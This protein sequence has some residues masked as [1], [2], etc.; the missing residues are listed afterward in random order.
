MKQAIL[1]NVILSLSA[2]FLLYAFSLYFKEEIGPFYYIAIFFQ[3]LLYSIQAFVLGLVK[4]KK[5]FIMFYGLLSFLKILFSIFF[6]I[7]Y[8]MFFSTQETQESQMVFLGFFI[9]LY[10]GHLLLNTI[11]VF[12]QQ[13]PS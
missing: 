6:I 11:S 4:G 7:I 3:L 8:L 2:S 12:S 9:L 10:F 13:K 5:T 1:K